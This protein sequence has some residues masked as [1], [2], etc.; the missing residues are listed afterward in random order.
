MVDDD[1]SKFPAASVLLLRLSTSFVAKHKILSKVRSK[2]PRGAEIE[3]PTPVN[4]E[5]KNYNVVIKFKRHKN[6]FFT[7]MIISSWCSHSAMSV[8]IYRG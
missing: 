2:S 7:M 1:F 8:A 5:T 4:V 3:L 6:I